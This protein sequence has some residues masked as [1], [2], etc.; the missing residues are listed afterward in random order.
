MKFYG[1][2]NELFLIQSIWWMTSASLS[3]WMSDS[4]RIIGGSF[5]DGA[6]WFSWARLAAGA[7]G[8]WLGWLSLGG[9]YN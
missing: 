1:S 2:D 8:S 3:F 7:E 5:C 6:C 4:S 9:A